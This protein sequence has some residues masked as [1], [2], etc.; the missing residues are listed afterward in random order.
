M[1]LTKKIIENTENMRKISLK[2][3]WF[4]LFSINLYPFI[5]LS[6]NFTEKNLIKAV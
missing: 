5:L 2:S 4:S 3:T 6:C 1:Q